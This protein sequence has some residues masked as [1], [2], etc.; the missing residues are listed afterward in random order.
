MDNSILFTPRSIGKVSIKNRFVR[1]ATF[2]SAANEDGSVGEDY[3]AIYETLAKGEIGLIIT[4]MI[5]P[6]IDGKSYPYQAGLHSDETI[7]GYSTMIN[8]VHRNGSKIFAQLCHGGRQSQTQGIRPPAPS[9]S[10]PDILYKVYPRAMDKN[11]ILSVIKTFGDAAKRAKEAGFDGIQIHAAHGYLLS[12]FLSPY[13]NRRRDEWGGSLEKRFNLIKRV[14]QSV[15]EAVGSTYPMTVKINIE[16]HTP[17]PGLSLKE[18]VEHIKRLLELGIDA[19]EISCGTLAFSMFNQSRGGVPAR[20]FSKT[21][22]GPLQLFARLLLKMAFP[23]KKYIFYENYNLWA[24]EDIKPLM[25]TIPLIVVGGLRS[26]K[27][28]E[29]IIQNRKADF[30]SLCRP[31]IR[32]PMIVSKWSAGDLTAVTCT[33]CNNCLGGIALHEKLKCNRDRTF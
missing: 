23:E 31:L 26:Y 20:A 24:S 13:L 5:F 33:N 11:E 32:Q 18:S 25:G 29:E 6:S 19:I 12:Q 30:V 21:M 10:K 17:K 1:S 16:D 22:P 14:Y 8:S 2:E 7:S 4:G 28:L 15:R 9:F 3:M 27:S